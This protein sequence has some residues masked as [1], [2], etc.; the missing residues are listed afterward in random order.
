[1]RVIIIRNNVLLSAVVSEEDLAH[2]WADVPEYGR[3]GVG[4]EGE[5][6]DPRDGTQPS[7]L[8][9]CK[10][11]CEAKPSCLAVDYDSE[12]HY[13]IWYST[14]VPH[15]QLVAASGVTYSFK[16]NEKGMLFFIKK[17]ML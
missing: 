5:L 9:A 14:L 3:E 15:D 8:L 6:T 7:S 13:C 4:L 11:L 1:M 17:D 16:R 2:S 12:Y 10:S